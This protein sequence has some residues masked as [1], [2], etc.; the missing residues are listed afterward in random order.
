MKIPQ[1]IYNRF[2][3]L[4]DVCPRNFCHED[5][6]P[7]QQY[8]NIYQS[9]IDQTLKIVHWE[10]IVTIPAVRCRLSRQH[11][12]WRFLSISAISLLLPQRF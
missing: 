11:L 2:E 3:L 8:L 7:Y 6:C 1:N 12:P 5:I 4:S 10:H 9:D